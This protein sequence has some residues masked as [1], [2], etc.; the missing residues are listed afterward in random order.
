MLARSRFRTASVITAAL[1]LLLPAP[2][3]SQQPAATPS[4]SAA[5]TGR[6]AG[7]I[8][9]ADARLPVAGA[10]VRAVHIGSGRTYTSDPTDA[11]GRYRLG[12][13]PAGYLDL[14]VDTAAG[15]Y[16]ATQVV[17]VPPGG[18]VSADFALTRYADRPEDWWAGRGLPDRVTARESIGIAEVSPTGAPRSFWKSPGGWVVIGGG[19]VAAALALGGSDSKPPASPSRP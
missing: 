12:G 19:V 6:L 16:V 18:A 7:R 9:Q 5:E 4:G 2:L 17:N 10:V 15:T 11:N 1:V 14:S 3:W 13:L 8:R